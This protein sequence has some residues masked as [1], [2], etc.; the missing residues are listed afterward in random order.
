MVYAIYNLC[1]CYVYT[2]YIPCISHKFILYVQKIW[3]VYIVYAIYMLC[4]MFVYTNDC[5]YQWYTQTKHGDVACRS[6]TQNIACDTNC[7]PPNA[8]M[9]LTDFNVLTSCPKDE[10][11]QWFLLLYWEIIP[12]MV[13]R[14]TQVLQRPDL[15]WISFGMTGTG[16]LIQSCPMRR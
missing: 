6:R 11:H 1:V 8:W 9:K 4:I 7:F 15:I 2:M 12:A 16:L 14:Y 3:I 10:L 5:I 13:Q